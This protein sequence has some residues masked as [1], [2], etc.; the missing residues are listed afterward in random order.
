MLKD[1]PRT[2]LNLQIKY[3]KQSLQL[4]G[5]KA[6]KLQFS[7]SFHALE[8]EYVVKRFFLKRFNMIAKLCQK[9][10]FESLKIYNKKTLTDELMMILDEILCQNRVRTYHF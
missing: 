7:F 5:C 6:N 10:D 3:S 8:G 1:S 2:T 9:F 4:H